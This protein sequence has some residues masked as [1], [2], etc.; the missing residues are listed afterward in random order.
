MFRPLLLPLLKCE[1]FGITR[2]LLFERC[3]LCKNKSK[4]QQK[5]VPISENLLGRAHFNIPVDNVKKALTCIDFKKPVL[6][7]VSSSLQQ[8]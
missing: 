7:P 3:L 8:I 2:F 5:Y 1:H 4:A 6:I